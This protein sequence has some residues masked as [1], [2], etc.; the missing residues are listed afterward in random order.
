[1]LLSHLPRSLRNP[2]HTPLSAV[3]SLR[4]RR[5]A[6]ATEDGW[7]ARSAVTPP[8]PSSFSLSPSFSHQGVPEGSHL[9]PH[10]RLAQPRR[11]CHP[12][13]GTWQQSEGGHSSYV[14]FLGVPVPAC[15]RSQMRSVPTSQLGTAGA[16]VWH[17]EQMLAEMGSWCQLVLWGGGPPGRGWL[18]MSQYLILPL[19]GAAS[20]FSDLIIG[21][22]VCMGS[23]AAR[24]RWGV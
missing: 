19:L 23:S 4:P 5:R 8:G 7:V 24:R 9:S 21:R 2:E 12:T 22:T 13:P 18:G 11:L 1:M 17:L 10:H 6:P 16:V 14:F 3:I 20:L 15:Q